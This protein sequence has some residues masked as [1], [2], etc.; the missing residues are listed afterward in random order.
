VIG[1]FPHGRKACDSLANLKSGNFLLYALGA[2]YALDHRLDDCLVLNTHERMADSCIANLFY[3]NKGMIYTPPLSEG[4]V[5][6]V[7]RRFLLDRLPAWGF[8]IAEQPVTRGDLDDADEIFLTNAL[9]G[10]RWVG[11]F[12]G[13]SRYRLSIVRDIAERMSKELP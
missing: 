1:V 4:C 10:I 8:P 13:K 11:D 7:M 3:T 12:E 5:A 9:K 6:G 2:R